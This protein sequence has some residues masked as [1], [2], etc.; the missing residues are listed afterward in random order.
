MED[1]EMR[2]G[3]SRSMAQLSEFST[4]LDVL[5]EESQFSSTSTYA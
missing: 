2:E 3:K 5:R 4:V 1:K